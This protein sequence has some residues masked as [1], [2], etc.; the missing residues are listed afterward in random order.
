MAFFAI[1]RSRPLTLLSA[2]DLATENERLE[3]ECEQLRRAVASHAVV[4]QALGAVVALGQ[5]APEEA[6]RALRDV[7]Q[8]TNTKLRTV[9]EHVLAFA[10]GAELPEA[11]RLEL[12][13]AIARYRR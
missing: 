3:R 2:A 8:R 5:I 11:E 12:R 6:W 9:A 10:Q 1:S 4:D 7:S 13:R